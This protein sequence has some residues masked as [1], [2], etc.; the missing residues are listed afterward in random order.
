MGACYRMKQDGA[1]AWRCEKLF[2][3]SG[4]IEQLVRRG[5]KMPKADQRNI[6]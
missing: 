4:Q 5:T 2:S 6:N 3:L 1:K